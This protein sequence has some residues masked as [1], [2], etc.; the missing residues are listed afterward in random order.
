MYKTNIL[1]PMTKDRMKTSYQGG[2]ADLRDEE[3]DLL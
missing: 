1:G 3:D 2:S